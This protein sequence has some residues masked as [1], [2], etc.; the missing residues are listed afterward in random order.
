MLVAMVTAA[1]NE[2]FFAKN[3]LKFLIG[4]IS[5]QNIDFLGNG[6]ILTIQTC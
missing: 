6:G 5:N 2:Y 1:A 3:V 4:L